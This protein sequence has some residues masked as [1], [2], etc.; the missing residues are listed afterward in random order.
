MELPWKFK[1]TQSSRVESSCELLVACYKRVSINQPSPIFNAKSF[2][3]VTVTCAS[4]QIFNLSA[5]CTVQSIIPCVKGGW[6]SY[7]AAT[8]ESRSQIVRGGK[9]S[10]LS[11]FVI[12]QIAINR[13]FLRFYVYFF[14]FD[15]LHFRVHEKNPRFFKISINKGQVIFFIF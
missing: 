14:F 8:F 5:N 13:N 1:A 3:Y 12:L 2:E 15:T 10:F 4:V 9:F 7:R 11:N 6:T